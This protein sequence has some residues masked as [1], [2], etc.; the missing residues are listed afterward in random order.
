M[1]FQVNDLVFKVK[2]MGEGWAEVISEPIY[3]YM[4]G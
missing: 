4:Q 3:C 1:Q 2:D